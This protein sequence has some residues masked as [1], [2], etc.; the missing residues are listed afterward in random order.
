MAGI[1]HKLLSQENL[2][3]L[4]TLVL[5]MIL[6]FIL[7]GK[8]LFAQEATITSGGNASGSG[9]TVSYTLGQLAFNFID[10]ANGSVAQGVQQPFEISA[11]TGIGE[12][13]GINFAVSVYPN[14]TTNQLILKIASS[15][16]SGMEYRFFD[17]TGRLL[18]SRLIKDKETNIA[19]SPYAPSTYYLKVLRN[20]TEIK[21]FKIIKN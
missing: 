9:G 13:V 4:K 2:A 6:L 17:F 10:G 19:T 18:E 7:S 15:D 1:I 21:T 14:P 11:V 5:I 12:M 16:I 8:E 20:N 3:Q